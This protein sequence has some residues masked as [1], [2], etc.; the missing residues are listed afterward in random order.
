LSKKNEKKEEK[1]IE[2]RFILDPNSKDE[3]IQI[4]YKAFKEMKEHYPGLT[5]NPLARSLIVRAY[6]YWFKPEVLNKKK[7]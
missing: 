3:D 7:R 6:D 4:A 1:E 2:I 5:K